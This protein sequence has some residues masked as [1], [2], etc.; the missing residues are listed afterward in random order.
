MMLFLQLMKNPVAC[1]E[2]DI[3]DPNGISKLESRHRIFSNFTC[4]H[5]WQMYS[6][7]LLA[8]KYFLNCMEKGDTLEFYFH[9]AHDEIRNIFRKARMVMYYSE[10]WMMP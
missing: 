1:G 5:Q 4:C 10:T 9:V 7:M 6:D 8:E 2:I 3:I